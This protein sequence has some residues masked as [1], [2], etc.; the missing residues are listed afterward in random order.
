MKNGTARS[1]KIT[2]NDQ[3]IAETELRDDPADHRGILSWMNQTPGWAWGSD[4]HSKP[5]LL[6]EAGSYG[7]LT[8][9]QLDETSK[10]STLETGKVTIRMYVDESTPE[11]RRTWLC[12]V[13]IQECTQWI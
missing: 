8:V 12:M 3:I 9:A 4:D 1:V 5:W 10:K 13:K 6:D 7:Y 11:P 2:A